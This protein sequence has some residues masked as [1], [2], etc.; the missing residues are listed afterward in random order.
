MR[1]LTQGLSAIT[2]L[3]CEGGGRSPRG[4]GYRR[5]RRFTYSCLQKGQRILGYPSCDLPAFSKKYLVL[6]AQ[7]T[8]QWNGPV[9]WGSEHRAGGDEDPPPDN[10]AVIA[11]RAIS[12]K[13]PPAISEL[14]SFEQRVTL[15]RRISPHG[16]GQGLVLLHIDGLIS[17]PGHLRP[18]KSQ[19][20]FNLLRTIG[21]DQAFEVAHTQVGG[22]SLRFK[23]GIG[24]DFLIELVVVGHAVDFG[25]EPYARRRDEEIIRF[26]RADLLPAPVPEHD[27]V[28]LGTLEVGDR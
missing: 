14:L 7:V 9:R 22:P 25:D 27:A 3:L 12:A 5:R 2:I 23:M 8:C 13:N 26:S 15:P 28:Y 10:S 19:E 16:P 4:V 20:S 21:D 1:R 18:D 24:Q 17:N 6:P 11:P